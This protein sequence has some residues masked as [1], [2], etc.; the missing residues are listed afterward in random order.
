MHRLMALELH[1]CRSSPPIFI[2]LRKLSKNIFKLMFEI[3]T[4]WVYFLYNKEE[5]VK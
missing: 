4:G 2:D 5:T 3:K 1:P